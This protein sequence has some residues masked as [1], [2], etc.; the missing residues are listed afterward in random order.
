MAILN[1]R[2]LQDLNLVASIA[3]PA[4]GATAHTAGINLGTTTPG[5]VPRVELLVSCPALPALADTKNATHVVEDSA[6]GVTYAA[7]ADIPAIVQGPGA[8][9]VGVGALAR[10]VKLPIGLRQWIRLSPTVDAAGGNNT[11][12]TATLALVF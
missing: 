4:A 8:G 11:G 2:S 7:V 1:T 5:R 10:Q 6:D 3:L 12:V 9:G